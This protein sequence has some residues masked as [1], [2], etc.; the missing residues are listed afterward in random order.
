MQ[1]EINDGAFSDALSDDSNL[2]YIGKN[3]FHITKVEEFSVS[4]SVIKQNEE[5]FSIIII[6][7][8]TTIIDEI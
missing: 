1:N 4:S 8:Q 2:Q 5:S 7:M 6:H 3:T